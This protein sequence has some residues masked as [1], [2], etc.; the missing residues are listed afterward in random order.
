LT[1]GFLE[2]V[3][4]EIVEKSD[5][6]ID[7]HYLISELVKRVEKDGKLH[8]DDPAWSTILLPEAQGELLQDFFSGVKE[9]SVEEFIKRFEDAITEVN[10]DEHGMVYDMN[11]NIIGY[12]G[13]D[14]VID[15]NMIDKEGNIRDENG[16]VIGRVNLE[17]INNDIEID[18]MDILDSVYNDFKETV[19]KNTDHDILDKIFDEYQEKEKPVQ[20]IPQHQV[21]N[22]TL[23]LRIPKEEKKKGTS[24][25]K[26]ENEV[27]NP[28]QNNGTPK[29]D[30]KGNNP[31]KKKKNKKKKSSKLSNTWKYGI[32]VGVTGLIL[33]SVGYFAYKKYSNQS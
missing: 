12:D 15:E 32:G 24:G 5:K 21:K 18:D 29:T 1:V 3:I 23:G 11:G 13:E 16:T 4:K 26:R 20:N 2:P 9:L 33:G 27:T 22:P 17:D 10:V 8:I 25:L 14:I 28:T 31:P 6:P 30:K 19:K 7:D